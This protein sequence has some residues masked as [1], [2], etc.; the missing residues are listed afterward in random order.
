[1]VAAIVRDPSW[2]IARRS[3]YLLLLKTD[4][5]DEEEVTSFV[6]TKVVLIAVSAVLC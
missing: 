6:I 1:M 4:A 5:D 2:H 3:R